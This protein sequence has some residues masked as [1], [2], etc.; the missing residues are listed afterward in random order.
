MRPPSVSIERNIRTL[1]LLEILL[2]LV[3]FVYNTNNKILMPDTQYISTEF[4]LELFMRNVI[5]H[6]MAK[7]RCFP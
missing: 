7:H 4:C 2:F 1:F 5:I 6:Q 3:L